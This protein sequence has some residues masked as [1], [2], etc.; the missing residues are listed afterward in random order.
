MPLLSQC[1]QLAMAQT[2][3]G[4]STSVWILQIA[5]T[6]TLA[7]GKSVILAEGARAQNVFWQVAGPRGQAPAEV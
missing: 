4:S 2:L 3:A 7:S 1:P 6:L 5:E